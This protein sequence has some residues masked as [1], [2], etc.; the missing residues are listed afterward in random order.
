[1]YKNYWEQY[2]S[3]NRQSDS[4]SLFAQYICEKYAKDGQT[5]TELGCGNGR[6]AVWFA[7]NGLKVTAFDQCQDEMDYLS[8]QFK[9]TENI[10]FEAKDFSSLP[11]MEK[12]DLVYSRFTLHSVSQRKE[13]KT[14][15]WA[16][17]NLKNGGHLCIEVRG[18]KNELYRQGQPVENEPDAFILDSH[19]RR[20]LDLETLRKNLETLGF[21][22]VEAE[23][24]AGFAPHNTT[25][26]NTTQHN[27]TQQ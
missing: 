5:V 14:L 17:N 1:M 19:Y 24:K 3:N 2:Y 25:Q 11:D 4:P 27:T 13:H 18:T 22:I 7:K 8:A 16:S 9:D 21:D 6:D 10:S 26:H 23:E 20:F 12:T 15:L